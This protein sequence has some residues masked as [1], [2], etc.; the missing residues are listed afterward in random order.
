MHTPLRLRAPL[1]SS[2]L[3]LALAI[4]P[5]A[6][7]APPK[8]SEPSF[9]NRPLHEWIADLSGVAP[10]TRHAAAYAIASMG[11]SAKAAVPALIKN[12]T[13]ESSA[14]RY[15]SALALGEIGP[16]AADAVPALKAVVEEDRSDDVAHMA[17]KALKRITG[18]VTE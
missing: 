4:G 9:D 7:Q 6:G 2:G 16:D 15:S 10:Y 1:A 18:E 14:V 13:D 8:G 11:A 5:L 12:L 17:R 3:L